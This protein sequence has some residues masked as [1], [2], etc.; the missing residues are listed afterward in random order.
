MMVLPLVTGGRVARRLL[1]YRDAVRILG[2]G[3]SPTV[4][5]LDHISRG[6]MVGAAPTV[7][8]VLSWLDARVEFVRLGNDLVR[9][10]SER[11][12]GLQ[13]LDRTQRLMA[14][15]TVIVV[16]AYFEA[17][18]DVPLSFRIDELELTREEHS[19]WRP[20]RR[21]RR[22]SFSA[23]WRPVLRCRSRPART[24][25]TN[26]GLSGT[27]RSCQGGSG[28]SWQGWQYGIGSRKRRGTGSRTNSARSVPPQSGATA[29]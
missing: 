25:S 21:P 28:C 5:A 7:G 18:V 13:R 15:H 8:A 10:M 27:T 11:R 22:A 1:S 26:T 20:S 6:L 14:A 19:D 17:L 24:T 29:S 23:P 2:G 9:G 4:A 12:S 3:Q 16:T